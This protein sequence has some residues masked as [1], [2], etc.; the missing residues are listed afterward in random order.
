MLLL[1]PFN[2]DIEKDYSTTQFDFNVSCP[3]LLG[4][5]LVR[6]SEMNSSILSCDDGGIRFQNVASNKFEKFNT[7]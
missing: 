1:C 7:G 2:L 4:L 5:L 3:Q 6:V